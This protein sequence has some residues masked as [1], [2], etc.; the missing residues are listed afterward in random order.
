MSTFGVTR[1]PKTYVLRPA[2]LGRG[3]SS[4]TRGASKRSTTSSWTS[5]G[6][7]CTSAA[8]SGSS[9]SIHSATRRAYFGGRLAPGCGLGGHQMAL[10]CGEKPLGVERSH[11]ARAGRRDRLAVDVVLHVADGEHAG[12]VRLGRVRLRDQVAGVV[13]VERLEE[14]LRV[15]VVADRDEEP[16]GWQLPRLVG[17]RVAQA[18]A[19]H[20]QVAEHLVD[21]GVRHPLDLVVRTRAVEHDLRCAEILAP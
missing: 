9:R 2:I 3:S 4:W 6:R 8:R 12:D 14:E 10:A 11:R 19:R 13:V 18:D 20:L 5:G 16:F 7:A 17:L 1:T 21:D 15:R